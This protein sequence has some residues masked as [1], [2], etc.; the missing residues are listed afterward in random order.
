MEPGLQQCLQDMVKN[1]ASDLYFTVGAPPSIKVYGELSRLNDNCL[2]EEVLQRYADDLMDE[3]QRSQFIQSPEM[4]LALDID[5]IGRFRVNIFRQRGFPAMVIR[6]IKSVIP[7]MEQLGLPINIQ[8]LALEK[9]GLILFVGGTNTGKSTS[10]AAMMD[11]RNQ[12]SSGHIICV[13]DPIE[14]IHSHK[15]SIINQRE[16]GMDTESYELALKNTLRQAPDV[17]LIGEINSRETMQHA[18]TFSET[19]HLCLSTL[20]ANNAYQALE[21]ITNFFNLE[22]RERLYF[23]LSLNLKAIVCQRLI[24][25]TDGKRVAAF[26]ILL[27]TPF[28][29]ELLLRGDIHDIVD[30][31]DKAENTGMQTFDMALYDLFHAGKITADNALQYA[32]S[33]NNLRLKI[34]L[35]HR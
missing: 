13:E 25:S 8:Q 21:R 31:M 16:I 19:G 10:L 18:I 27:N 5:T 34:S 9:R 17:I 35:A 32:N 6:H 22:H 23:D 20:H 2:T 24:P 28:V 11:Y 3:E 29:S 15:K 7:P 12:H 4:N 33:R 1:E 14:Y 26:E 30:H